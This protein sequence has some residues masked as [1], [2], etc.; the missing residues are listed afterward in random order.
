M[1]KQRTIER[2]A[3]GYMMLLLAMVTI[4]FWNAPPLPIFHEIFSDAG[5]YVTPRWL[6]ILAIALQAL[7]FILIYDPVRRQIPIKMR[8]SLFLLLPSPLVIFIVPTALY[9]AFANSGRSSVMPYIVLWI[10]FLVIGIITYMGE[11]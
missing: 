5:V 9:A 4:F 11:D 1:M 6:A 8:R 7:A 10:A 3:V 2:I